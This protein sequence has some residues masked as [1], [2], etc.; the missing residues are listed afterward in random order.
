MSTSS[1]C[2][3]GPTGSPQNAG[4]MGAQL[5]NKMGITTCKTSSSESA[6]KFEAKALLASVSGAISKSSSSTSGCSDVSLLL[7]SF[8]NTVNE[9]TCNST[10]ASNSTALTVTAVQNINFSSSG[11]GSIVEPSPTCPNASVSQSVNMNISFVSKFT[12]DLQ[13]SITNSISNHM[14]T[15]TNT[16]SK[17]NTAFGAT[18]QG[19]TSVQALNDANQTDSIQQNLS[20]AISKM[21]VSVDANQNMTFEATNGGSLYYPCVINQNDVIILQITS[22]VSDTIANTFGNAIQG[23]FTAHQKYVDDTTSSGAPSALTTSFGSSMGMYI[24]GGILVVGLIV[25]AVYFMK[26]GGIQA[27]TAVAAP[28]ATIA[29]RATSSAPAPAVAPAVAPVSAS[30]APAVAPVSASFRYYG[31]NHPW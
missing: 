23:Y 2:K 18:P 5:L 17:T 9:A 19:K 3:G 25:V 11:A 31:R 4:Q 26:S 1:S 24:V 10:S 21:K 16:L 22:V 13:S 14:S 28:E 30:S 6:G 7:N 8:T 15:F 12:A 29:R 27:I 20:S